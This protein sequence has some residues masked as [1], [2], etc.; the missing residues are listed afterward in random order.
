MLA[1]LDLRLVDVERR[2]QLLD[3][4][5]G[6]ERR[7]LL[8]HRRRPIVGALRLLEVG[9]LL[10]QLRT[11]RRDLRLRAL[12]RGLGLRLV[13][14]EQELAGRDHLA[15]LDGEL[16]DLAADVRRDVDLGL[17]PN[18]AARRDRSDEIALLNGL[19]R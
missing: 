1:R 19:H 18:L 15:F 13:D 8:L 9:L 14:L 5:V 16:H 11:G 12:D 7:I 3:L 6:D 2:P 17:R 10:R 4:F